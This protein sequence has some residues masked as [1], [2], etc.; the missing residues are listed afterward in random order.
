M[1]AHDLLMTMYEGATISERRAITSALERAIELAP[2][3]SEERARLRA[4]MQT[5]GPLVGFAVCAHMN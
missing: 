3:K 5:W 1:S 2:Y 4:L